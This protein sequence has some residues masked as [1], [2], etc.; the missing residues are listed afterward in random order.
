MSKALLLIGSVLI[1]AGGFL[2]FIENL[3]FTY[4]NPLDFSYKS[5]NFSFYFP[6]GTCIIISVLISLAFYLFKR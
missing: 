3:D 6:L 4:N 5:E 1:L 2:W